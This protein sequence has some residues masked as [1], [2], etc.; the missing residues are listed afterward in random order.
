MAKNFEYT[1]GSFRGLNLC[2]DSSF[3]TSS[4][5]S[6][7]SVNFSVGDGYSLSKRKGYSVLSRYDGCGR[8]IT[9]FSH[10]GREWV[11]FVRDRYVVVWT[12][13]GEKVVGELES[14]S[15]QVDFLRFSGKL[16]ILDGKKIK[17]WDT[18]TFSDIEPYRPLVAVSTTPDGAGVAFEEKNLLTGKVRQ[19]FTM[20]NTVIKLQLALDGLDSV[21]YI[22]AG[23]EE[24]P[25]SSCV[26]D[27]AHGTVTVPDKYRDYGVIDGIEVGYTKGTGSAALVHAMRHAVAYGGENDTRIFLYGD[28]ENPDVLRYSGVASG[29]SG[30]EYFPENSFNKIGCA[31]PVTS[32][33]RHYDRLVVF[34]P[35]EAF[36][37]YGE[38][39][40]DESGLERTRFPTY[41]L[42]NTVGCE[43]EGFVQ[44]VNN[45][46]VTFDR[47]TLYRWHS[48]SVR[49]E[50]YAEDMAERVKEGFKGWCA[51]EV[52]AFDSESTDEL[53][54]WCKDEI[55]VYNYKLD[56]F[57]FWR[58]IEPTGFVT[59]ENSRIL[60][61]RCDGSLCA[62]F[63][64][65]LDDT[66]PVE[67]EWESDYLEIF[68][69]IKNL[70]RLDVLVFPELDT[71]A[72]IEWV[73]DKGESGGCVLKGN[74]RRF[75][76]KKLD[77]SRLGFKMGLAPERIKYR[78]L[79]KRF[80]RVKIK[81]SCKA[82]NTALKVKCITLAGK[83]LDKK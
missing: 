80:E 64:G 22:K 75:S 31:S 20:N 36:Y 66:L 11:V 12:D 53:F 24:I 61:E 63:E 41:P 13:D 19:S 55:Y 1:L 39:V 47:G 10:K 56:V 14:D 42:S 77:F 23:D 70:H 69:G 27:L 2:R 8:G 33:V 45:L 17:C 67:A 7:K 79:H 58:G 83:A 25:K 5:Q 76:F 21:D 51:K 34:C 59:L 78:A 43:P 60:F 37:L 38:R 35:N 44:V 30:M 9:A 6:P 26:I 49:D 29:V 81:L 48:S 68:P 28:P 71:E 15:G 40:S 54:V 52:K 16:Y 62:L 18:Q 46:P 57:Y 50:R 4:G 73:S 72:D 82:P 74:Y 3:A 65:A 32:V